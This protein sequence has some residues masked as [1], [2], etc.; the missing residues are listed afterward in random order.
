MKVF[1]FVFHTYLTCS[2]HRGHLSK[3]CTFFSTKVF[4]NSNF[5]SST[6]WFLKKCLNIKVLRDRVGWVL[7]Q[8]FRWQIAQSGS[9]VIRSWTSILSVSFG[10]RNP[11]PSMGLFS[12][13][14]WELVFWTNI[15]G[16]DSFSINKD[17]SVVVQGAETM[18]KYD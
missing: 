4:N 18:N 15:D 12:E 17:W 6:R 8:T 11:P 2:G 1:R 9:L 13:F 3:S 16:E 14:V 5:I 10:L 7:S